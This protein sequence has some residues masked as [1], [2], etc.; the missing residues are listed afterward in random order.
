MH[1]H[2]CGGSACW[3]WPV[4]AR[5]ASALVVL[6]QVVRL[7]SDTNNLTVPPAAHSAWL[8]LAGGYAA[9]L[10]RISELESVDLPAE[11]LDQAR[12]A[13]RSGSVG[14][15]SDYVAEAV[16]LRLAKDR[17]LAQVSRLFGGPPPEAVL[18]FPAA[19][20]PSAPPRRFVIGG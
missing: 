17:A 8:A 18:A 6:G 20:R 16:R 12:D 5:D 13:A 10:L 4:G 2:S 11:L 9:I 7:T 14:S 19:G 1:K 15:V 3:R